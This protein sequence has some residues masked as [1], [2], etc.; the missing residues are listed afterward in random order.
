MQDLK[1]FIHYTLSNTL[2]M[3]GISI[4][5][6]ADVYFIAKGVGPEGIAALNLALP[7]YNLVNACGLMLAV[8]SAIYFIQ[9]KAQNNQPARNQA[10]STGLIACLIIGGLFLL[11]GLSAS[12]QLTQWLG[13]DT[14][15]YESTHVYLRYVLLFAPFFILNQFFSLFV[16]NDGYPQLAMYAMLTGSLFNTIFD[17]VFIFIFDMGMKGAVLATAFS[18][19]LGILVNSWHLIKG[20]P[21]FSFQVQ[22][23]QF[24]RLKAAL[25]AGLPSFISELSVGLVMLVFNFLILDLA[26]NTGVA[27]YGI[28]VNLLFVIIAIYNGIAMGTQPLLGRFY[29]LRDFKSLQ[30]ILHYSLIT[31]IL[32]SLIFYS[33]ALL[34]PHELIALFNYQ[35][36]LAMAQ[37][38]YQAFGPYFSQ[39]L[40]LGINTVLIMYFISSNRARLAQVLAILKGFALVLPLAL[41][42]SHIAGLSGLWVS[43][44]L[45]EG[46]VM[47]LGL[48]Y[49]RSSPRL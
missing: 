23:F 2:S 17:Y 1:E 19:I 36:D 26:G 18:P 41:V 3:I 8:G 37:V 9:A 47:A 35:E 49:W 13:A 34:I 21:N 48:Y 28:L 39:C 30:R 38:A 4:Y 45:S 16:K 14:H 42:L 24:Q 22:A 25:S 11:I 32:V 46:I 6:M 40:F 33:V 5:I 12:S 7:V 31:V 44:T 29:A 20:K 15:V 27:A 10:Y 43:M